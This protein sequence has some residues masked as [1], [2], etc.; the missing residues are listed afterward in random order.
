M[1]RKLTSRKARTVLCLGPRHSGKSVFGY[2]LFK[3]LLEL[4]NDACV[5]DGDY[6][7]PTYR[8][9]RIE[10]FASPDEYARIFTTPNAVKL[11]KLT[12]DNF[13]RGVQSTHDLIEYEGIIV[14]DGIGKHS[15]STEALLELADM[16]IVLCSDRFDVTTESEP[17]SYTI[18]NQPLHP[19]DFY[20]RRKTKYITIKTHYRNEKTAVFDPRSLRAELFDLEITSV[21]KGNV[22]GIPS[23]TR[24]IIRE[25][26]SFILANWV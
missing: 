5:M 1:E 7:A 19:F 16:L 26:A 6:Y 17:C 2:I 15:G 21:K 9:V 24:Q 11:T 8:R 22:D 23:E 14:L 4:G 20:A 12:E 3:S 10:E 18:E 13:R 25:I